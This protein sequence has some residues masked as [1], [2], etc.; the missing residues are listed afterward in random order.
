[1]RFGGPQGIRKYT[2]QQVYVE[3][4]VAPKTEVHWYPH[5]RRKGAITGRMVSL[6][7]ARDWRRRLGLRPKGA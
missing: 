4:R 3:P 5:S 2:H 1:V 7:G 6:I